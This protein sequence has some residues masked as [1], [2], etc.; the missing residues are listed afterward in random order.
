M[1]NKKRVNDLRKML[2]SGNESERMMSAGVLRT[3]FS[4]ITRLYFENKQA[5]GLG[6]LVFNPEAPDKSKYIT[7]G[8]LENDL[9]LAQEDCNSVF[10]EGFQ[11]MINV[12]EKEKDS[13]L[14]IVAMAYE[15]GIAVNLID[16]DQINETIDELSNG[17]VY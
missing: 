4:D 12:I 15:D 17:L 1:F 2:F 9:S 5:M 6:L 14:A 13:D 3:I 10:E 7:K 8:D 11:K 16:P